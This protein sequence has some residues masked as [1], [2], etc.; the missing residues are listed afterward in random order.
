M[1]QL[2]IDAHKLDSNVVQEEDE[3]VK[4]DLDGQQDTSSSS[5]KALDADEIMA[6]VRNLFR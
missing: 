3:L 5:K 4:G 1:L 6:N 2:M